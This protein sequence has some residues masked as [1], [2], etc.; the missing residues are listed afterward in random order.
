MY[1]SCNYFHSISTGYHPSAML[2]RIDFR[3]MLPVLRETLIYPEHDHTLLSFRRRAAGPR[4]CTTRRWR[5][6]AARGSTACSSPASCPID[7][8]NLVQEVCGEEKV[9]RQFL[10]LVC[11]QQGEEH[12]HASDIQALNH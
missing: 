3:P 6:T 5:A 8:T 9:V 7:A 4:R 1:F 12:P 11:P 2:N 10:L